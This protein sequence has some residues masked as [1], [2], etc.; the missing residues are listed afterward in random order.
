MATVIIE[1]DEAAAGRAAADRLADEWDDR[2][3]VPANAS[4]EWARAAVG[5]LGEIIAA[6]PAM[7]R[8]SMRGADKGASTLTPRPFQGIVECLQNAD[9]L[10]ATALQVAYRDGPR[11]ELLIV[12][13][14]S[15]V[16]LAN[17]GAMLLPWLSTKDADPDAAGRFGIGQRTLNALGGPIAL[18]A[19][20]FHFVMADDGPV[21]CDPETG[22][23]GVYDPERRDTML[24]IPLKPSVTCASVAEAVAELDVD[25]LI[26]L[27]SIRTLGFRRLG[28]DADD[29]TFAVEV[30]PSAAGRVDFGD[31]EAD[32]VICDIEVTSP[33]ESAG[34][35][36]RRYTTRRTVKPDEGRSNKATGATTPIGVCVPM[37]ATRPFRLYDR[38]P[39][40]VVTGLSIGLDAQFDP[41]S[42]R[43]TLQPVAWNRNRFTDLAQLVA[44][45]ALEAFAFD[46]VAAWNHIPL[47]AEI[48]PSGDWS[49]ERARDLVAACHD[50]LRSCLQVD[51]GAG[52]TPLA[53]LAYEAV[54]LEPL[55]TAEDVERLVPD[56]AALPRDVRD[57]AGRWRHVLG[58]LDVSQVVGLVDALAILDDDL[59]RGADWYV[60]IA[61]LATRDGQF[62][63][64]STK[65]SIMLDNGSVTARPSPGYAWVLVKGT[66]GNSLAARLGLSRMMHPAYFAPGAPTEA[67]VEALER[68]GVLFADRDAAADVFAILARDSAQLASSEP[69]RVQDDDL[70][71]LRDTWA[72]LPRERHGELG[73]VVGRRIELRAT[74]HGKDGRRA[75]G[76][77]RPV[78][79]YL[80]AAIDR[81]VD[82]FAKAAGRVPGLRWVDPDYGR[83]LKQ[84]EGRSA[85]GAQKL[86]VAWGVAREPRLIQPRDEVAPWA[87]DT[88]AASP[89]A[90]Q[91]Q[92]ENQLKSIRANQWVTHLLE[93]H[94][95]PDAD[96]VAADIARASIKTRRKRALALLAT[97][98]RGWERRYQDFSTAYP[99]YA[100]NGYWHLSPEVRATWLARLADQKWM[101]DAGSGL[102]R[103]LDLQL[104]I[105]GS[106][107]RP[108]ERSGT[109]AKFDTQIQRSGILAALGVKAG[110]TQRDLLDRLRAL[111]DKPVSSVVEG[112][113]L[114]VYQLL[115]GTLRERRDGVAESRMTQA[116]LRNA[117]RAGS[118]R[119]GLLL[120][121]GE[122]RSPETVLRGPPI[123]GDKR[124]FAPHIEGLEQLWIALGV[125]LPSVSDALAVLREMAEGQPSP[126]ELGIAIR[127]L[128]LVSAAVA[129]MSAQMRT[130]LRRLPLWTGASWTT[131]RPVYAFEGEGLL[132]AAPSTMP[133][134][135]PGLTSFDTLA[136]L[137]AALGIVRLT[138][139]DFRAASTPAYG[140]AE[141][142]ELRPVFS[143]AVA[144]LRQE[145]VRADRTLLDSL[146]IDWD[147]LLAASVVV[148]PELSIVADLDGGRV[149]LPAQAH[150]GRD[151]LRLIVRSN[152]IAATA[153]GAGAAVASLFNGDRQKAAWAWAAVW[154]RAVIGEQA[155]GAVLPNARAE[156]GDGKDRLEELAR[157]AAQRK[158]KTADKG[159]S[160]SKQEAGKAAPKPT[161]QVRK[162]REL[163]ELEPSAGVIVNAGATPTGDLVFAKA[164]KA[165]ERRFQ[166]GG[167]GSVDSS[168]PRTVLPPT[169]DRER[170]ALDAVRRA[171]QLDVP[172]F[173]DLRAVRGLGVDAI[174]ELRQCYEIKMS[175]GTALPTDV[176]LT[177]SEVAAARHDPD[178]FLAVV[179]GLEDGAGELRVRFI[180]DPLANLDVRVH[181]DLTLTGVDRA[182]ALEFTFARRSSDQGAK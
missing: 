69:I 127:A 137:L 90:T 40:P 4:E 130:A 85:I 23:P 65:Q 30:S 78:E 152:S 150:V 113:A 145:F 43:S 155:V 37:E 74:W 42:A 134:W 160:R 181:S 129:D 35:R 60:A 46:P 57:A 144:L 159:A 68:L 143:R 148:D 158:G 8:A 61:A 109:V 54:D 2:G 168:T 64:F 139:A 29:L 39:L 92:T 163:G 120:V 62:T 147:D 179:T 98:S 110:P 7:L 135:R 11:P 95:S 58:E 20:P 44:W 96:A 67:F 182:E 93:D 140:L 3:W 116:Q 108:A 73:G 80:P 50:T 153:E 56:C 21:V 59:D 47:L 100:Y 172:R 97:L 5:R 126:T 162:L 48:V 83:L 119:P 38:M 82:S 131:S 13:D 36:Y 10:G 52:P 154:P 63:P 75:T 26:F 123:F 45:A 72:A 136:P 180:F 77:A 19:P 170:M 101:P 31:E 112:E 1:D 71:A 99:A 133:V 161:V 177:A 6:Q 55:L 151:P 33:P 107:P 122:W 165:K 22:I 178:F 171:L 79:L 141:G 173:N 128:T 174:D 9:D 16:T 176:T 157:Q 81:E 103:P 167:G 106:P 169:S 86:L 156:R 114:A 18:H 53:D 84:K 49:T 17:V 87:R 117:F 132:A 142:D 94:W 102:Q 76:W 14:G 27:R 24:V 138:P 15:P 149:T 70:L 175:S 66:S 88:R 146:S 89:I 41:D 121:G 91:M 166:P 111:Q 118:A 164:R 124:I 104:Q 25:A 51:V 34:H 115:A 28:T 32:V 125:D 12:H 105:P